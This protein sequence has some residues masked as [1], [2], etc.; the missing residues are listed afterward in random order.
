LQIKP[1]ALPLALGDVEVEYRFKN[2][3]YSIIIARGRENSFNIDG[4]KIECGNLV[5]L[6]DGVNRRIEVTFKSNPK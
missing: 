2:S 3:N 1:V 6:E 5:A 4:L